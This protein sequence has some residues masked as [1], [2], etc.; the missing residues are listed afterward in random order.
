[1]QVEGHQKKKIKY[2]DNIPTPIV[3]KTDNFIDFSPK[4]VARQLALIEFEDYALIHPTE[5]MHQSWTKQDKEKLSP[6]IGQMIKR[7]NI[8]PMWVAT[9]ILTQGEKIKARVKTITLFIKIAKV[10]FNYFIMLKQC[11]RYS[12]LLL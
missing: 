3:P 10:I 7:S 9:K 11:K 8:V 6:H 1:M 2:L 5:C 12:F 4:E